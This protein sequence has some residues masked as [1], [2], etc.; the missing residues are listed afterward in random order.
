MAQVTIEFFKG[1]SKVIG[2]GT[3]SGSHKILYRH[4]QVMKSIWGGSPSVEPVAL[5]I[6]R[7]LENFTSLMKNDVVNVVF[8][9]DD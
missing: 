5:G 9:M 7:M 3:R 2:L 4:F 6:D 1:L 8:C